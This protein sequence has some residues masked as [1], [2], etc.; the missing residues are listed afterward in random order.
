VQTSLALPAPDAVNGNAELQFNE[1]KLIAPVT[2]STL[3]VTGNAASK[4]PTTDRTYSLTFSASVGLYSGTF[5]PNWTTPSSIKPGFKG[6]LVR[7]GFTGPAGYGYFHSNR[8]LDLD[9]E[10]G[11]VTLGAP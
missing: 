9:P 11:E 3:N 6:I 7:K 5:T 10:S 2:I 8:T 1:G 4:I